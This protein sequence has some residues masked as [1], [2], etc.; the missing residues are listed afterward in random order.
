MASWD[1]SRDRV[2]GWIMYSLV[3]ELELSIS[4]SAQSAFDQ[5]YKEMEEVRS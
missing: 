4:A 5:E 3:R 2:L 1:A